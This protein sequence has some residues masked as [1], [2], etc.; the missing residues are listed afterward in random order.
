VSVHQSTLSSKS[1]SSGSRAAYPRGGQQA[2]GSTTPPLSTPST[3][4]RGTDPERRTRGQEYK[5]YFMFGGRDHGKYRSEYLDSQAKE[6]QV[7]SPEDPEESTSSDD[8]GAGGKDD[9]TEYCEQDPK[10]LRAQLTKQVLAA[11]KASNEK[12][13]K[14]SARTGNNTGSSATNVG[15]MD[16]APV[17]YNLGYPGGNLGAKASGPYRK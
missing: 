17:E 9:S 4:S 2:S 5:G 16:T 12:H 1:A 10:A 8:D 13:A 6:K 14:Q 7:V 3:Q 15:P 11:I